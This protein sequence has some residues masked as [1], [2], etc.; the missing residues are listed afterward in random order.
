MVIYYEEYYFLSIRKTGM[1]ICLKYVRKMEMSLFSPD[2]EVCRSALQ[3]LKGIGIVF[4]SDF[5][6]ADLCLI[7]M[8]IENV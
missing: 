6:Q 1:L 5:R 3:I 8:R 4:G 2:E 7:V